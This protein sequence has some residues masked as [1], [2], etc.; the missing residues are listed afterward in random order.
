MGL[1]FDHFELGWG[2]KI[3]IMVRMI[4]KANLR[5]FIQ[6][7][8][9]MWMLSLTYTFMMIKIILGGVI[10]VI[11][12]MRILSLPTMI[13]GII[14]MITTMVIILMTSRMTT[15]WHQHKSQH[16]NQESF[17]VLLPFTIHLGNIAYL[18]TT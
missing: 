2:F 1:V 18:L 6:A 8:I 11:T 15:W 17:Y 10:H 13:L 14:L 12:V 3:I 16:N 4:I 5:G 9:F 7:A